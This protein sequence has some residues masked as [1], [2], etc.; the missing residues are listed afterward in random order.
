MRENRRK[1]RAIAIARAETDS[2]RIAILTACLIGL[3]S[4]A[5]AVAF[6]SL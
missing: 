6:S 2:S 5:A 1:A 3:F 4:I